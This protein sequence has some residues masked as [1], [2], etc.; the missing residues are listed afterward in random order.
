MNETFFVGLVM[1]SGTPYEIERILNPLT[2]VALM[3]GS[4]CSRG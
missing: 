2:S 1:E 3:V 4:T